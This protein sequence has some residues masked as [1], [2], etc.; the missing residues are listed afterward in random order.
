MTSKEMIK[1]N[2]VLY[3]IMKDLSKL[4]EDRDAVMQRCVANKLATSQDNY[5][6]NITK[7]YKYVLSRSN[8][9]VMK[10]ISRMLGG[11]KK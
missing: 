8:I 6:K 4:Q 2:K 9:K 7:L 3:N 5:D 1:S 11:K 10:S